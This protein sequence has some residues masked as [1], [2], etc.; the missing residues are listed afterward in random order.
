MR[1][2]GESKPHCRVYQNNSSGVNI[3]RK[4]SDH[5]LLFELRTQASSACK[6]RTFAGAIFR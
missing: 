1:Y 3:P 6:A 2:R 5:F 4:D